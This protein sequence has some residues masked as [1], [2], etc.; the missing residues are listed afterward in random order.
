MVRTGHVPP[1][2]VGQIARVRQR[3]YL[4]EQVTRSRRK[5]LGA[6]RTATKVRLSCVDDDNQGAP[7]EVLWENELGPEVLSSE[8]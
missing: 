4:V 3:T 1:P 5:Q 8:A 2:S 6:I 7:L